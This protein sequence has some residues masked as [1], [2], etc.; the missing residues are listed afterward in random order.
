MAT[1][2]AGKGKRIV[3]M[4]RHSPTPT[5]ISELERLFPNHTLIVDERSFSGANEIVGRFHAAR[6]DEMVVVAPWT[7]IRELVRRGLTPIYAE[8]RQVPCDTEHEVAINSKRKRCYRF[9]RFLW[10]RGVKL[11]LHPINPEGER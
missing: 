2:Y 7:V 9:V 10:C 5:Q 8:M 11:D 1:F 6:G 4:S 3:W